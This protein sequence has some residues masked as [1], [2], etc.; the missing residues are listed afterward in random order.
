MPCLIDLIISLDKGGVAGEGV[1]DGVTGG[2]V[3][4]G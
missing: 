2:S 4:G 3:A 1:V